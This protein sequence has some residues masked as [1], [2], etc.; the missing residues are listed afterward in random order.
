MG[1]KEWRNSFT[2]NI[3]L[4]VK[5]K[6]NISAVKR[7]QANTMQWH[8]FPGVPGIL[9]TTQSQGLAGMLACTHTPFKNIMKQRVF[10]TNTCLCYKTKINCKDTNND[11][12]DINMASVL[13]HNLIHVDTITF[14]WEKHPWV[15]NFTLLWHPTTLLWSMLTVHAGKLSLQAIQANW[16]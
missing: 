13:G 9:L 14:H 1:Q 5:L 3:P 6:L 11:L 2:K 4:R 15:C 12:L 7:K 16:G 10:P 8:Q